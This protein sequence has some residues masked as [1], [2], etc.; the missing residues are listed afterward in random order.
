MFGA[1]AGATQPA[2]A[3]FSFGGERPRRLLP[4]AASVSAP[5]RPLQRRRQLLAASVL[6]ALLPLQPLRR[7]PRVSALELLRRPAQRRPLRLRRGFPSVRRPLRPLSLVARDSALEAPAQ[8]LLL[9]AASASVELLLP[10]P[11]RR[12]ASA[13]VERARRRLLEA[14]ALVLAALHRLPARR[15]L[16]D[17]E[18]LQQ[19]SS[20]RLQRRLARRLLDSALELNLR[21]PVRAL[22]SAQRRALEPVRLAQRPQQDL[23]S[24]VVVALAPPHR[25]QHLQHLAPLRQRLLPR[26]DYSRCR[27]LGGAAQHSEGG[28]PGP[29][30]VT[31]Q[32]PHVQH[33]R[34]DAA[35][36]LRA[37]TSH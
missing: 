26:P 8:L 13:L 5:R 27:C 14:R 22:D 31:L 12:V 11:L 20:V 15:R 18:V 4:Q 35:T 33:R 19:R 10:P 6:A 1:T 34:S 17:L 30:S 3:G 9:A 2:A 36:P 25:A 21:P 7:D 32:I 16:S 23:L 28:V 24:S 29:S 37:T